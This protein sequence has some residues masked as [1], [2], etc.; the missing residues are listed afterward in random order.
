[1]INFFKGMILGFSFVIPGL[2]SATTAII[3]NEYDTLLEII[4][5]FYKFKI[6]KRHLKF[7]IGILFGL[8]ISFLILMVLLEKNIWFILVI[9]LTINIC[10]LKIDFKVKNIIF[11]IFGLLLV[12][13]LT[14]FLNLNMYNNNFIYLLFGIIVALGFVLPGLSGSLLMFNLG[15]YNLLFDIVKKYNFLSLI[16]IIF[17]SGL[18]IGVILWSRL[19]RRLNN[20]NNNLIFNA[21]IK[22]MVIGSIYILGDKISDYIINYKD[23][24]FMIILVVLTFIIYKISCKHLRKK[25]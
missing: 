13:F 22:G 17:I 18:L 24:L 21:I 4:G 23:L 19:F 12:L 9:F 20:N 1:M 3:L 14:Y 8:L 15:I 7:I 2:C 10:S 11:N 6:L 25:R 5:D 16:L